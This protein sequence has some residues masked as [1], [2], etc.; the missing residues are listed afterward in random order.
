MVTISGSVCRFGLAAAVALTSA[1][2]AAAQ[3]FNWRSLFGSSPAT[4]G[5]V[6]SSA[7]S[8]QP[9]SPS[10]APEWSGESGASGHPL[11][12]AEAIRSAAGSFRNCLAGLWPLA[13]RRGVSQRVYEAETRAVT[14]DLRIMDLLDAQPEFTKSFWDYL[15]LLVSE[16]RIADGRAILAKY[17]PAFDAVE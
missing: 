7:P 12:T 3:G 11:M 6:S 2:A 9:G 16:Q 1:S 10:A 14:P 13:A 8:A 4:T 17:K 15:D 5:S